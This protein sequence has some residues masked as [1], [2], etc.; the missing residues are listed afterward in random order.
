MFCEAVLEDIVCLQE[1]VDRGENCVERKAAIVP[2]VENHGRDD[3]LGGGVLKRQRQ[4]HLEESGWA[5]D[6]G[7]PI[8]TW[9]EG[10]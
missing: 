7:Q 3:S 8:E 10:D 5:L 6:Q 9:R 1:A 4:G 2:V